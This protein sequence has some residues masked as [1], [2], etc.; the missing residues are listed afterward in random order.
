MIFNHP[1]GLLILLIIPVLVL[2]YIIKNRYTEQ[3]IASTYLWT[4][5]EKFIK[6]RTPINKIVGI[7][8]LILQIAAAIFLALAVAQPSFVLKDA[9]HDYCIILDASGSMTT[10]DE[11]GGTRFKAAAQKA[12]ELINSSMDGSTYTLIY[13]SSAARCEFEYIDDKNSALSMLYGLEEGYGADNFEGALALAQEY[14]EENTSM[15]IYLYTD[16]EITPAEN[17]QVVR[18]GGETGNRAVENVSF[19][20]GTSDIVFKGNAIS[21]G[22]D[23]SAGIALYIDGAQTPAQVSEITL[24]DGVPSPFEFTYSSLTFK[25]A[26]IAFT[27]PDLQ[28]NDDGQVIINPA[29]DSAKQTVLVSNEPSIFLKAAL[30]S[31]GL[32]DVETVTESEFNQR[33][34]YGLYIF[35]GVLPE[36]LPEDGAVWFINP[37][38]SVAGSNFSFRGVSEARAAASYSQSTSTSVAKLLKGVSTRGFELKQYSRC[39]QSGRFANLI[40]CEGNPLVFA[41]VDAYGNREAVFAFDFRDAAAFTLSDSCVMLL[42]NLIEYC[43]PTA[44]ENV[45]HYSGENVTV[46]IV[47]GAQSVWITSPSGEDVYLD[48]TA[49]SCDFRADEV[50]VYTVTMKM[51]DDSESTAE[52]Y[53]ALP[54]SEGAGRAQG[55]FAIAGSASDSGKNGYFDTAII[56]LAILLALALADYGVYSYEQYQLR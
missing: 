23:C 54:Q 43:F 52:F 55:G 2:I 46:N 22:E 6:R 42:H 45:T 10:A 34:G 47:P 18:V 9:A 16:A 32:G 8:S 19:T 14:F 20:A 29:S 4:L 3:T 28:P 51:K 13:A 33:R 17:V 11:A 39:G 27:L 12:A 15:K 5:S 7:I 30:S 49:E 38:G 31:A 26:R 37:R 25:S 40:S 53:C 50:G 36:S 35:D 1:L 41:G 21:Y 24:E 48:A 44:V 56:V